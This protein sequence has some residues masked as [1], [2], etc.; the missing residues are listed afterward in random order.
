MQVSNALA[1]R[2]SIPSTSNQDFPAF[3]SPTAP[4][5]GEHNHS[6]REQLLRYAQNF[7]DCDFDLRDRNKSDDDS[8]NL[9]VNLSRHHN[10]TR[11]NQNPAAAAQY[12]QIAFDAIVSLESTLVT[13]KLTCCQFI[14][15]SAAVSLGE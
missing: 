5:K 9:V 8:I 6:L 7:E 4:V 13:G 10:L 2:L 14:T 15:T 11:I 3:D 12:F 1:I